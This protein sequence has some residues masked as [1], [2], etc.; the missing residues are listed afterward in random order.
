MEA[1]TEETTS[2]T[3]KT[4]VSSA[5]LQDQ[6]KVPW[7]TTITENPFLLNLDLKQSSLSELPQVLP[8]GIHQVQRQDLL[9]WR[10]V[11]MIKSGQCPSRSQQQLESP[12][13]WHLLH[14]WPKLTLESDGV[15]QHTNGQCR[16]SR[17][18][19]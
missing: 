10:V 14:E 12:D 15:L 8:N 11:K 4:V 16:Q 2:G 6:G 7:L 1:C 5:Q 9:I 19:P 3:L 18:S 17:K 13:T